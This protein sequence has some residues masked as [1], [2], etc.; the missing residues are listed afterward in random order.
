VR[1]KSDNVCKTVLYEIF[2]DIIIVLVY[3]FI[4][5]C[6]KIR[7]KTLTKYMEML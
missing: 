5:I 4:G 6:W 7:I 2:T 3:G 1:I